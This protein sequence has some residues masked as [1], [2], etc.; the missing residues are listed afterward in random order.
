M[1]K[2]ISR[3]RKIVLMLFDVMAIIIS[4]LSAFLLR[5]DFLIPIE[6]IR[7]VYLLLPVFIVVQIT[8]FIF[9][10]YYNVIWRFTSLWDMLN[11]IK[12]IALSN[13]LSTVFIG[14]YR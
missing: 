14:F 13:L 12:A 10:G 3:Y 5:F 11:I 9:N 8:I 2:F 7:E 6:Y 1:N 4:L